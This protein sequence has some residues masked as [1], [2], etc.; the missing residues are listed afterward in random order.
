LLDRT[1]YPYID[2]RGKYVHLVYDKNAL[3]SGSALDP[4]PLILK[5]DTIVEHERMLMGL[6]KYNRSPKNRQLTYCEHGN[7]YYAGG[8]GVHLDIDWGVGALTDP[9]NIDTW[10]IAHEYGHVNQIYKGLNWVGTAE[11]TNN[12]YSQWVDYQMTNSGQQ[13]TR[14]DDENVTPDTGIPSIEGGRINGAIYRTFINNYHVQDT[15]NYDVFKV[16][17]PFWQLSAYY[18]LAGAARNAPI[19]SLSNPA[20]NP[21]IDFASWY[22]KVA[23]VV[24]TTDETG[25]T[26]GEHLLNFVKYTCDAVEENLIPFFQ[27]SGFLKPIDVPIDDYGVE[28][29]TVTQ[30]QIDD[31]IAYVQGKGYQQP[32]SPVIH[33]ASAH[34]IEMYK[35]QLPLSGVTGVGASL[36]GNYLQ[37]QHSDWHNAVAYETYDHSGN[38][39]YVSISGTGDPSNQL[40]KVYYPF[41]ALAVYAVG[42]DGQKI[43]VYPASILDTKENTKS[44]SLVMYPNPVGNGASIHLRVD[45]EQGDYSGSV[46]TLDGRLMTTVDGSISQIEQQLNKAVSGFSGGAYLLNLTNEAGKQSR[47]KFVK[48]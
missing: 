12:V 24:R 34:S 13:Y 39:I 26:N 7:G 37:V 48:Q 10:G 22:G 19:L 36:I 16:L 29:L 38:L 43:L 4:L 46:H 14:L 11:V 44:S 35:N 9:N 17:V 15:E 32:V 5:Y 2:V 8:L 47:I 45:G 21:G 20:G 30:Q 25:V 31:L 23:E 42:F 3:K 1:A 40:T 41:N 18:S 33:Y 27:H 6:F 28:Q